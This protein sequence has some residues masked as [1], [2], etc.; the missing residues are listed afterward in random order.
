[1]VFRLFVGLAIFLA[2][3]AYGFKLQNEWVPFAFLTSGFFSGLAGFFGMKTAT[4]ASA[5]TAEAARHS[6]NKGLTVAFRSGA[7]MGLTV[8]G[9]ALLDYS[10]WFWCLK[11]AYMPL[12]KR[13]ACCC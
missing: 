8:V 6:L 10:F 11:T 2:I 3:L 7:V 1:M 9:L 4:S 5:R 12:R 13:N